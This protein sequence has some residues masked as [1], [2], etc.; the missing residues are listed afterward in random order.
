MPLPSPP[1]LLLLFRREP[2]KM[3]MRMPM[4][5]SAATTP[6]RHTA[7]DETRMS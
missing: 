6:T 7:I 5:L 3:N 4:S 2:P 1:L